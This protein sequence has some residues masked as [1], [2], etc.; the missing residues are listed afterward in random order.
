M[1][2]YTLTSEENWDFQEDIVKVAENFRQHYL[3]VNCQLINSYFKA[4]RDIM[5]GCVDTIVNMGGLMN[6]WEDKAGAAMC[7]ANASIKLLA[8]IKQLEE[9]EETL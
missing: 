5:S 3:P 4:V 7:V 2:K 9:M 6:E 1:K 8:C